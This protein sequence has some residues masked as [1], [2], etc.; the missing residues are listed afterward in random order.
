MGQESPKSFFGLGLPGRNSEER[1]AV[2]GWLVDIAPRSDH[3]RATQMLGSDVHDPLDREQGRQTK[4]ARNSAASARL[5]RKSVGR[6]Q[7]DVASANLRRESAGEPAGST[8]PILLRG[9]GTTVNRALCGIQRGPSCT[10]CPQ[11][12]QKSSLDRTPNRAGNGRPTLIVPLRVRRAGRRRR[13]DSRT[14]K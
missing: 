9:L 5:Q 6:G 7:P 2:M 8:S 1:T 13:E 14:L 4:P 3:C 11:L 12:E 10:G